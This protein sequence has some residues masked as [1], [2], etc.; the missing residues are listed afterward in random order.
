MRFQIVPVALALAVS[1]M[2]AA[3]APAPTPAPKEKTKPML[4]VEKT[5]LD[6]GEVKP[7]TTVKGEFVFR[8]TGKRPVKILKAAPS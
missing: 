6:L 1:G 3:A 7:G 5:T 2:A 8:N 4:Q